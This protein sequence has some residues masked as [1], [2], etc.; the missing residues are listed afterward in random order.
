MIVSFKHAGLQRFYESGVKSGINPEH[1]DKLARMLSVL[2]QVHS[3][4]PLLT[5]PGYH[6]PN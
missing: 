5:F 4:A 1:A 2:D 6:A 3:P